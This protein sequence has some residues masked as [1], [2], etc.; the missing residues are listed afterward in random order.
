MKRTSISLVTAALAVALG[1]G[2]AVAHAAPIVSG[3]VWLVSSGAASNAIPANVPGTTPDVTFQAPS[4]PLFFDSR[5][6]SNSYNLG[7]FLATGGAF[8]IVENTPGALANTTNDHLYQFVGQVSVTNGQQFG[9]LHDDGLTLIIGGL[10]VISAPGPTAPILTTATYTGPSGTF[11]FQLVYGECCGAPAALR[12]NLPLISPP[13][14]IP[15]PASL[16]LLSIGLL[17]VAAARRRK[18]V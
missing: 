16:A 17:G 1:L 18:P 7:N 15:E 5:V 12:V 9:V 8:N 2:A 6:G 11:A 14:D 3:S 10:T 4:D 13:A